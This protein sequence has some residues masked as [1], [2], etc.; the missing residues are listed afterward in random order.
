MGSSQ[1]ILAKG[2]ELFQQGQA[3]VEDTAKLLD[4]VRQIAEKKVQ[5]RY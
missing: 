1:D 5:D 2:R 4:D 3:I